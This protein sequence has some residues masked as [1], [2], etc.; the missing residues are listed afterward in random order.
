MATLTKYPE[1]DYTADLKARLDKVGISHGA[2]ARAGGFDPSQLSRWFNTPMQPS[3][4]NVGRLER[5]LKKAIH[6]RDNG[7]RLK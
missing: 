6:D 1:G 2:L 7:T 4:R 5:A 3:L